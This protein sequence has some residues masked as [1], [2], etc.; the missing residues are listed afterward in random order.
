MSV[1]RMVF[2]AIN[3]RNKKRRCQFERITSY[4]IRAKEGRGIIFVSYEY[5]CHVRTDGASSTSR[6]V[7]QLAAQ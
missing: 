2:D 5:D 4:G 1:R 6:K 3:K 7:L